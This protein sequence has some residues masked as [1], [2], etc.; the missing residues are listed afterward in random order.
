[1]EN[2]KKKKSHKLKF[3]FIKKILSP[4][5]AKCTRKQSIEHGIYNVREEHRKSANDVTQYEQN[6]LS[7]Q[8]AMSHNS[9]FTYGSSFCLYG[10]PNEN[11]DNYENENNNYEKENDYENDD[12]MQSLKKRENSKSTF[13]SSFSTNESFRSYD[14]KIL[15]NDKMQRKLDRSKSSFTQ[16]KREMQNGSTN[17]IYKQ[18]LYD[19]LIESTA[20]YDKETIMKTFE[21]TVNPSMKETIFEDEIYSQTEKQTASTPMGYSPELDMNNNGSLNDFERKINFDESFR[22]NDIFKRNTYETFYQNYQDHEDCS[23]K[24]DDANETYLTSETETNTNWRHSKNSNHDSA[25]GSD[26]DDSEFMTVFVLATALNNKTDKEVNEDLV[27]EIIT[28]NVESEI[29][30]DDVFSEDIRDKIL[31]EQINLRKLSEECFPSYCLPDKV[32]ENNFKSEPGETKDYNYHGKNEFSDNFELPFVYIDN[33]KEHHNEVKKLKLKLNHDKRKNNKIILEKISKDKQQQKSFEYL[34]FLCCSQE[35]EKQLQQRE[36]IE[37][38]EQL[39]RQELIDKEENPLFAYSQ[40]GFSTLE[41]IDRE[42]QFEFMAREFTNNY[43]LM[44]RISTKKFL[45]KR[46]SL[47]KNLLLKGQKSADCTTFEKELNSLY[48][49]ITKGTN[50]T[51]CLILLQVNS[52]FWKDICR[53]ATSSKKSHFQSCYYKSYSVEGY[54]HRTVIVLQN[55]LEVKEMNRS[56]LNIETNFKDTNIKSEILTRKEV[57]PQIKEAPRG[58]GFGLRVQYFVRDK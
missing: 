41:N 20:N 19:S 16:Q 38:E 13:N 44:K 11:D 10:Q 48:R 9:V 45:L 57:V 26:I 12:F 39:P 2:N 23:Y 6:R 24:I 37:S 27:E 18:K 52:K 34:P 5:Q 56:L 15:V 58:R 17:N 54:R 46:I 51:E 7:N 29:N 31:E 21:H 47:P 36:F 22:R 55:G 28:D 35:P 4:F 50:Y 25:I 14:T 33:E 43:T 49:D 53:I 3:K 30:L 32:Q 8:R 42:Y 40:N 1:M